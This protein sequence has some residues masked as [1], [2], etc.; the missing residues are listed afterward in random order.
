MEYELAPMQQAS[1]LIT[2]P[3]LTPMAI[4]YQLIKSYVQYPT[5]DKNT[6]DFSSPSSIKATSGTI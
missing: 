2:M 1:N 3:F 6:D 5:L 4:Y